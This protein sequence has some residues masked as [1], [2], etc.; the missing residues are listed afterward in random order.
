MTGDDRTLER[1]EEW[2]AEEAETEPL[3]AFLRELMEVQSRFRWQGKGWGPTSKPTLQAKLDREKRLDQ[4]EP[5]LEFEDFDLDWDVVEEGLNS[6]SSV[7]A[8]HAD[9]FAQEPIEPVVG[10]G[11]VRRLARGWL[12][13][14]LDMEMS[15]YG[16]AVLTLTLN[17]FFAGYRSSLDMEFEQERWLQGRCP[18]CGGEPDLAYLDEERGARWLVCSRCDTEWLFQRMR[19]PFCNTTDH[20]RLSHFAD[21][22]SPYR[23]DVCEVCGGYLKTIDRRQ[24]EGSATAVGLERLLTLDLDAHAQAAGYR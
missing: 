3:V 12:R 6:T 5:L 16:L 13:G 2:T 18:V 19:C 8:R 14:T 4:G 11:D 24:E 21:E 17:P 20:T 22:S 7:F 10:P 15:V 1:L 9:L 23:T